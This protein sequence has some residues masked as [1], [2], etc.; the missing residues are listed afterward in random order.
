[1][2]WKVAPVSEIR[3]AFVHHVVS[4][5][6]SVVEACR[7][8]SISRKTGHKWLARHRLAPDAPLLDLSKR[9]HHSPRRTLRDLE[10]AVVDVR[11]SFGWGPRKIHA[12]LRAAG[13]QLPS[14]RTLAN[15]L[16]RHQR[17]PPPPPA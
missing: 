13:R 16:R 6:H 10:L 9:P 8:F 3:L 1:M 17:V 7:R 4:L 12:Y 5:N 2:P 15:I 11:D 14:I